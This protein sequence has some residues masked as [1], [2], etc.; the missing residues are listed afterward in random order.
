MQN[1][2]CLQLAHDNLLALLQTFY[3]KNKE[4]N[5][6]DLVALKDVWETNLPDQTDLTVEQ[7]RSLSINLID[8]KGETPTPSKPAQPDN[9]RKNETKKENRTIIYYYTIY[10][11]Y[12]IYFANFSYI[13]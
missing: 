6:N 11:Y 4:T 9:I 13:Y 1:L 12:I 5:N 2:D 10:I 7:R 8:I 3:R